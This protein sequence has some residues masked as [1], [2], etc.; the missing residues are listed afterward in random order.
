MVFI[1]TIIILI[2]L[3]IHKNSSAYEYLD[4]SK[5]NLGFS[6][7]DITSDGFQKLR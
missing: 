2:F 1:N 6:K 3:I 5:N 7:S 4:E